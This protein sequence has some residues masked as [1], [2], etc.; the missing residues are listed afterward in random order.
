VVRAES[1]REAIELVNSS[2][3]G[4]GATI[5]TSDGG[6]ARAFEQDVQAGMVGI[7]VPIPVPMAYHSFGGWKASL[8]GD[9]HVHGPDGFRFY[10]RGK[11]V[12]RRWADPAHRGV[13]LGF[14]TSEAGRTPG[15][16]T[17]PA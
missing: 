13:D 17:G 2:P 4:N 6:V 16:A 10:T 9:L 15:S 14:P 8:F 12:T 5:F 3:Y 1:Y 7:N 11:V